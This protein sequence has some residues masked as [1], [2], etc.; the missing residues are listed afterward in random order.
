[1]A[2]NNLKAILLKHGKR[3]SELVPVCGL[4]KGTVGDVHNEKRKVSPTS[5]AKILNGVNKI[6]ETT[7]DIKDIFPSETK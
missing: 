7:Y 3:Q 2:K 4:S 6:C 1:M 5:E